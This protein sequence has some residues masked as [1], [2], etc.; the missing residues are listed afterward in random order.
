MRKL[1]VVENGES[2]LRALV[3]ALGKDWDVHAVAGGEHVAAAVRH[4]APEAMVI[5][6]NIGPQ[7]GVCVLEECFPVLPPVILAL[8]N[9]VSPYILAKL[10]SL[11]V[12]EVVR[13]PCSAEYIRETLDDMHRAF[14][15]KPS[16]LAR[17]LRTL[18]ISSGFAGYRCLLAAVSLLREDPNLMLKEVYPQVAKRCDLNDPRCVEHVIR[19]ALHAAWAKRDVKAWNY[20]FPGYDRCPSNKAFILRLAEML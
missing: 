19:T 18:G 15:E 5:D 13:I 7:N 17:H 11:G 14:L 3:Q 12:G 9:F 20:Y 8:T 2:E 10:E 6:L 1:L 4:L 16:L